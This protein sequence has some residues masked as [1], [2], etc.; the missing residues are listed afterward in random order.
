MDRV[1]ARLRVDGRFG[2][3]DYT[4]C[5]QI[6]SDRFAHRVLLRSKPRMGQQYSDACMWWTPSRA[7]FVPLK[8]SA[9]SDL[10][11]FSAPHMTEMEDLTLLLKRR[12]C[13]IIRDNPCE[14]WR[15]L[16]FAVTNMRHGVLRLIGHPYTFKE[17]VLDVAQTQH[18]YL[19]ALAMCEF[20]EDQWAVRLSKSGPVSKKIYRDRLG[21]WTM[22]PSAAQKLFQAGIPVYFV[23][24]IESLTSNERVLRMQLTAERDARIE[25]RDWE[26]RGVVVAFP[27]R[28]VGPPTVALHGALSEENRYRDLDAYFVTMTG[29]RLLSPVGTK[30]R[31]VPIDSPPNKRR[32]NSRVKQ[33]APQVHTPARDKWRELKG[34]FIPHTE[35]TWASAFTFI[36]RT[37]FPDPG[38]IIYSE[39]RRERNLFNWLA[40]RDA[41][42]HRACNDAASGH[43]VPVG[44]SNELWRLYIG[45]DFND[46]AYSTAQKGRSDPP[47]AVQDNIT[48]RQLLVEI[49]G[50]PPNTQHMREV[51]WNNHDIEWGKITMHDTLL[52]REIIWDLHQWSFQYDLIALD[53]Y[54]APD[55]WEHGDSARYNLL[56]DICGGHSSLSVASLPAEDIG[57]ASSNVEVRRIAYGALKRLMESWGDDISAEV[58]ASSELQLAKSYCQIFAKTLGRPPIVP[59][60]IPR[61]N[62]CKGVYPYRRLE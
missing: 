40:V 54:L 24:P 44:I 55:A 15:D 52:V 5:P 19:D 41:T 27:N 32:K 57:V 53:R 28:Y 4:R 22:D 6:F 60:M 17:M 35:P 49:Y 18:Y 48:R 3:Q 14:D 29:G 20:V 39:G 45:S 1:S 33:S 8:S 46:V 16:E 2:E 31:L 34:D 9:F 37:E 36:K 23:R 62:D 50:R 13:V 47:R 61:H 25:I 42:I 43:A 38:M 10:G 7:N 51:Q 30:S 56:E 12:A 26:E 21:A 59:K 58:D 11:R